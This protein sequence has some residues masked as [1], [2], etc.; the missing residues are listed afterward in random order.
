MAAV[1]I[2]IARPE[3]RAWRYR[4]AIDR[5]FPDVKVL[6]ADNHDQALAEIAKADALIAYG[7]L[8][9]EDL[10][11]KG[12]NLSWI[13]GLTTGMDWMARVANLRDQ[14]L[15]TSTTG[16]HGPAMAEMA[17]LLMMSLTR[18]MPG[19]VRAQDSGAWERYAGGLLH[20]RTAGIVGIGTTAEHLAPI[21]KSLGMTVIG[22]SESN[23][24]VPGFDRIHRRR[25]LNDVVGEID[26]LVVLAPYT[27]ET[28]HMINKE[29]LAA[30]KPTSYLINIARG[31]LVDQAALLDALT[32][33]RIA[34]ASLDV[35]DVEPLPPDHALRK[36][37]N[38]I[39]TP[40]NAGLFDAYPDLAMPIVENNL[41]CYLAG[42]SGGMINLIEH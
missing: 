34:G 15:V 37:D 17:L 22:F 14:T 27:P 26:H 21:C 13:H 24:Q 23:R 41:R 11:H 6:M 25:E 4:E 10:L 40:H 5:A 8:I 1:L 2:Y 9:K 42:D 39:V 12:K 16:I 3:H 36:L 38:V 19:F 28:H 32:N 35:F 31:G 29:I 7:N 20:Q 18:G 30:M 33:R